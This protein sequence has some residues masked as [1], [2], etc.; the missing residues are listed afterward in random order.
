MSSPSDQPP[1]GPTPEQIQNAIR[2]QTADQGPAPQVAPCPKTLTWVEFQLVDM[3]GNPVSGIRYRVRLPDGAV[4]EGTLDRSGKVRFDGITPGTA[5]I[6][7][8]ELDHEAWE[9]V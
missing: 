9:R 5:T 4:K 8:F 7:Y 6:N 2:Q 3:E 1:A